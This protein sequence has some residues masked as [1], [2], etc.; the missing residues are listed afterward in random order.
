[1][2]TTVQNEQKQM[3]EQF[4][5]LFFSSQEAFDNGENQLGEE[6]KKELDLVLKLLKSKGYDIGT[7]IE[8]LRMQ[9]R[10][11]NEFD[12]V[13]I[14]TDGGVRNN[15]RHVKEAPYGASAFIL[16]GDEK[17]LS[18]GSSYIGETIPTHAG[19]SL[20]ITSILAE[21]HGL[22][23]AI[24]F[25]SKSNIKTKRYVFL[26]DSSVM[27]G[28]LYTKLPAQQTNRDYV[29]N[30]R[31]KFKTLKN[32]EVKYIPRKLNKKADALV[33]HCLNLKGA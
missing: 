18:Q 8:D 6:L 23:Q 17:I 15:C 30:L 22:E 21:Y 4:S 9:Y 19:D 32:F 25:I 14:F 5:H 33:N 1:M 28:H 29:L 2:L 26:T 16:Y 12:N 27:V 7:L 13:V 24:D 11:R 10:T 31:K 20:P 3:V